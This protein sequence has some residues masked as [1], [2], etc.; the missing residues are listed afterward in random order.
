MIWTPDV[1]A[2]FAKADELAADGFL[3]IDDCDDV[4]IAAGSGTL[5]L[6]FLQSVPDITDIIAAIGGGSM[7]SG[8]ATAARSVS[9]DIRI[10]GVETDGSDSMAKAVNERR[11]V[12]IDVTTAISTLGVPSVSEVFLDRVLELVRQVVVVEDRQAFQGVIEFAETEH[13]W[14]EPAAGALIPAAERIAA[15]LPSD[16]VIG[17]V[18]CGGNATISDV[19]GFL[20]S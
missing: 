10:W 9:P 20:K 14:V 19:T 15:K 3:L 6:E 17:L 12:T 16:A 4:G 7:I 5:A 8:V 1:A 11:P 2:A 13:I 18:V